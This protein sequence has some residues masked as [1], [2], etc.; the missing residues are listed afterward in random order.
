MGNATARER[1][2]KL[3]N[4]NTNTVDTPLPINHTRKLLSRPIALETQLRPNGGQN[5]R[6]ST[7]NPLK[8]SENEDWLRQIL[9]QNKGKDE[10]ETEKTGIEQMRSDTYDG[11]LLLSMCTPPRASHA[12]DVLFGRVVW[13]R[14]TT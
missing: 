10:K 7:R 11:K 5:R 8:T 6:T 12:A 2:T 14:C 4:L 9:R 13:K 1:E 3:P